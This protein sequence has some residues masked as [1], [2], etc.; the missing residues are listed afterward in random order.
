MEGE[1]YGLQG[2]HSE[3]LSP[4]CCF[5]SNLLGT[6]GGKKKLKAIAKAFK[7][8]NHTP[9]TR[10]R[11]PTSSPFD[12]PPKYSFLNRSHTGRGGGGNGGAQDLRGIAMRNSHSN[13]KANANGNESS[14]PRDIP[15]SSEEQ[16]LRGGEDEIPQL[17][18]YGS[19]IGSPTNNDVRGQRPPALELPDPALDPERAMNT[20]IPTPGTL[21]TSKTKGTVFDLQSSQGTAFEI[22][23][24]NSPH[25]P[26][27][28]LPTRYKSIFNPQRVRSMPSTEGS[29]PLMKRLFSVSAEGT[30]ESGGSDMPLEAYR[31]LDFR[32]AEFFAFL[33]RQLEKIETF[34]KQKEDEATDRL[35]LLREQLH[36]MRDR[37]LEELVAIQTAKLKVKQKK[38]A[39]GGVLSGHSLGEEDIPQPKSHSL[40]V[41][42]LVPLDS[43][44]EAA[45]SGRFGKI[46]KGLKELGTPSGLRPI[47]VP[48]DR[49]DYTRRPDLPEVPYRSAKRKLKTA[50]QEYYRGLELLKSYALLNR[51]AFRKI[52]KKYDKTINARPSGRYMA[53]KVNKAWF[54]QSGVLDGHI[55]TIEDLYARYFEQGNHKVAVG[56]LRIKSTRAG[57]FTENSFRNGLMLAAGLIFGVQ[58]LVYGSHLLL[59]SSPTM[60][61]NASYLLQIYAGYFF[62]V[63]LV[64]L[65]CL[66]CRV[67]HESKI[68]YVFVF[69]FDTRHHL[70]WRQLCE[71]PCF[72]TF[73][74]GLF[75]W[76]NFSRIGGDSVYL[77]YPVILIGITAWRLLLAGLYPV[78]FRDFFLGDM[79]CSLTY[80]MGNIELFFCLYAN[81]W[82]KPIRCN[83]SH[84]RLLGFFAAVPGIWRA[85]QCVRRYYDTRNI[86]PHLVNCGKYTATILY[87]VTL[88]IYRIQKTPGNRALF[89]VFATI[90]SIYT[91]IWDVIMDWSLGDPYAKHRFL[92]DTLGYKRIWMYYVAMVVDPILRF[93][94]IFYA[95][96]PLELQQP[97]I[98]SFVVAFSE[99]C[100]RGMWTLFRVE[101]E[102]CTNVGRFRAS[103]DIPLPYDLPS[104]KISPTTSRTTTSFPTS[105]T[106]ADGTTTPS[107][108][109]CHRIATP[110]TPHAH[111][112]ISGP[113]DL[114]AARSRESTLSRRAE[115][116]EWPSP[117][118]K[119]LSRVG[120]IL[121]A[122]HAQD[123]ERKRRPEA[124]QEDSGAAEEDSDDE[125]GDEDGAGEGLS[126]EEVKGGEEDE[127]VREV[128]E[129]RRIGEGERE[130]EGIRNRRGGGSSGIGLSER[131]MSGGEGPFGERRS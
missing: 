119:G 83:S 13:L 29:R 78:E 17:T 107:V 1:I 51:T 33:D 96:Y 25:R 20:T 120:S 97:A 111:S 91:S 64:L 88:S 23:R 130:G 36:I 43:A 65:F 32:Q 108:S 22:G 93:N 24:T 81:N 118:T 15:R 102:H 101:N 12:T 116:L 86:F 95:I 94:W 34:Y 121:H 8:A 131:K 75:M 87:Y 30:P 56:K 9:R 45:K 126:E 41:S 72:F 77:Y 57:D 6:Q 68:N 48:D 82:G 11:G 103:R 47:Q 104:T 52:N 55:R 90:N 60:A 71:L 42:W 50:L 105:Q 2:L 106:H 109:S 100:R 59:S 79:F 98:L 66:A 61:V 14:G 39:E 115:T 38:A 58:G 113:S 44:L 129:A 10:R 16:P 74:L 19:I 46:K 49:R 76:L 125:E 35:N 26:S 31:D 99:V 123:F 21:S 27:A 89:I 40:K 63:Y 53:E 3:V 67:W 114:E 18:R 73:L 4:Q 80:S 62:L 124:R 85:L 70:D 84:S 110:G 117:L 112:H 69:E 122:A 28:T 37:R 54:V 128:R 5:S 7:N 127:E 92:R